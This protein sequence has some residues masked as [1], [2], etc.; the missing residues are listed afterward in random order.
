MGFA[1]YVSVCVQLCCVGFHYISLHV[2]AYMAIFRCV[3]YFYF[4]MPEGFCFAAFFCLFPRGHTARL[5]GEVKYFLLSSMIRFCWRMVG[6]SGLGQRSR[7][8]YFPNC[9]CNLGTSFGGSYISYDELKSVGLHEKPA[10][11][12]GI[13]CHFKTCLKLEQNQERLR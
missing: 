8:V 2:S 9:N 4:H 5:I 10:V 13:G 12:L 1:G 3:G 6:N 11:A 7:N